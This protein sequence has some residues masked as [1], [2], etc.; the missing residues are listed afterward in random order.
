MDSV[1]RSPSLLLAA[2]FM[3]LGF[4][5]VTAT[6]SAGAVRRAA[7]PRKAELVRVIERRRSQVAERDQAV[8]ALRAEVAAA[9]ELASARTR[10]D[11]EQ[12]RARAT[13]ALQAGTVAVRGRGVVVDLS[14]SSRRAPAGG[15]TG[16]HRVHDTDL[17][18]VVNALLDAGAEA[19]SINDSRL[20][21]TTP[22]RSA[23]DTIVVNFRPL[24]PPYR[25]AA[26]G[27]DRAEFERSEIA[28]RFSRWTRLFG[29]GFT[30]RQQEVT[31]PG[32][33]GRVAITSA[34]PT[35]A[36]Q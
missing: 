10:F 14:D 33:T 16:A 25:V 15:D 5:L 6:S 1:R 22:I 35:E 34:R 11:R 30:V 24:R 4:L 27:A 19:V 18:M 9:Q 8:R 17:Q 20:V 31:V 23:G 32:Y 26:I 36:P 29:L 28:R 12:A 2:G 21:A 3:V 13:L 7:V